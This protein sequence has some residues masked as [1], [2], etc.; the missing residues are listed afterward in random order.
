MKPYGIVI[1]IDIN[2]VTTPFLT[3]VTENG[4]VP[5]ISELHPF[6][7]IYRDTD[8]TDIAFCTFCQY[9]ATPSEV[10]SDAAFKRYQTTENG[11]S[12]D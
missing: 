6:V 2:S 5:D 12:V 3:K 9:S 8:V 1:N 7:D 11:V 10:F 4:R